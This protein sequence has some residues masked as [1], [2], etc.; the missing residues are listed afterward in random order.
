MT[1]MMR[2][3]LFITVSLLLCSGSAGGQTGARA[4]RRTIDS[5]I[6]QFSLSDPFIQGDAVERITPFGAR[7]VAPLIQALSDS[8][9]DVRVSS[10]IAL[11]RIAPVG[12]EAVPALTEALKDASSDLRWCSAV[13]LGRFK[14]KA[15]FSVKTLTGLLSDK[16]RNI[17]WAAYTAL[18]QIDKRSI[19]LRRTL[20][21]VIQQLQDLTLA[22]MKELNV[23]GVSISII[24]NNAVA[25]SKG[26]GLSDASTQTEVTTET[27]FEACSM[28][29]P[30]FAFIVLQLV[31]QERLDLDTPLYR[32]LPE[33]FVAANDDYAKLITARMILTHTSG[34]PN[35]RKAGDERN[36]PLPLY[37]RPGTKFSYSGEGIF[38]LQRVVEHIT[39]ESLASLSRRMLFDTLELRRTG[40]VWTP[41]LSADIATGHDDS[42]RTNSRSKYLRG[43]AAYTL[44]TTPME[45]ARFIIALMR[46]YRGDGGILS[47]ALTKEMIDNQVR[48]DT[49]D[50]TDRPGRALGVQS[51][52]GLGW[53]IDSTIT[54]NI[55]YHSGSNQ[56]GFRCYS[57]FDPN[58]GSGIVIMTNSANGSELW[59]RLI[60]AVGDL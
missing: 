10:A 16:D 5:L 45:Y 51:Y 57:Q 50:V 21:D 2:S 47:A 18:L 38:Y 36:A 53:G 39:N 17:R 20:P 11:G 30:V 58:E 8:I 27:I 13:A 42:G 6:A 55:V 41:E 3:A 29:K 22:V 56:T 15:A 52:R 33:Q 44:Y 49:R 24:R 19:D 32:Y 37:F 34:M 43:N 48:V 54:G 4:E 59:Q 12:V 9:I 28:S 23:P 40:F 60:S 26:F 31:D 46:S 35:W 25:W 14:N 1:P 7:A